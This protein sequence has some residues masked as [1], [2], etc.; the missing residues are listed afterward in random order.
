M[1]SVG[2]ET[3]CSRCLLE[4]KNVMKF[5]RIFLFKATPEKL[6]LWSYTWA[7][8]CHVTTKMGWFFVCEWLTCWCILPCGVSMTWYTSFHAC[9][10]IMTLTWLMITS[11]DHVITSFDHVITSLDHVIM[12]LD[13]VIMSLRHVIMTCWHDTLCHRSSCQLDCSCDVV[14]LLQ[15]S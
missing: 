2:V 8:A 6:H 12:S 14:T 10:K 3:I 1:T 11:L 7:E 5:M 9:N 15:V 4:I 13:H